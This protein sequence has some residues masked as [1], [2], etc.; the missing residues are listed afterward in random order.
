MTDVNKDVEELITKEGYINGAKAKVAPFSY[1]SISYANETQKGIEGVSEYSYGN[2]QNIPIGDAKNLN[3]NAT[4]LAKGFRAQASSVPRQVM[5]HFFGR[6]SFN[7]NKIHEWFLRFLG[8]FQTHLRQDNNLWSP[9]AKYELGD[10]CFVHDTLVANDADK[11]IVRVFRCIK[12]VSGGL[13]NVRP[14]DTS[15]H[16][17]NTEY[18]QE[19]NV[20]DEL[21]AVRFHG[22]ATNITDGLVTTAKL[23]T[24][25][26]TTAKLATGAVTDEKIATGAVTDEKIATEAVT[27]A[28]LATR[29]VTDEKIATGA[30]TGEKIATEAVTT[31][32][33]ATGAVTASKC[34]GDVVKSVNGKTPTNGNVAID[35]PSVSYPISIANGG[36]GVTSQGEI[37]KA[38]VRDLEL[39]T[40]DVTDG[41]EF[42]SSLAS[43][44]GF[45]EPGAINVP[46]K[47]K[48]SSLWNYIKNKIISMQEAWIKNEMIAPGTITDSRFAYKTIQ[49]GSIADDAIKTNA[50]ANY[51]VTSGKIAD[52]SIG[53]GKLKSGSNYIM[54]YITMYWDNSSSSSTDAGAL[55][56]SLVS[57]K[58]DYPTI[59][60][61]AK[62]IYYNDVDEQIRFPCSGYIKYKNPS[63]DKSGACSSVQSTGL[64]LLV[65][66]YDTNP[67]SFQ[68]I[69]YIIDRAQE[70]TI[71]DQA[72]EIVAH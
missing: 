24:G 47:R 67:A 11:Q 48:C 28:K 5:N 60:S 33:L 56:F 36:T 15:T 40:N 46:Y 62:D 14:I 68:Q 57:T 1:D 32:K 34:A 29:A 53:Y 20:Y 18:W 19:S 38:F 9:T 69:D 41:T 7:L 13:V 16:K 39:G 25:A 12:S 72:V 22:E 59:E 45:S 51:A 23:A 27:T 2:N 44:N 37:N 70:I 52:F 31:A 21:Y 8:Y 55:N 63:K 71:I 4:T 66:L 58:I 49:D 30:V 50:I 3:I 6:T 42:V 65:K 35:L 43:N 17:V 61:I 54:H 64:N 10:V 26:V